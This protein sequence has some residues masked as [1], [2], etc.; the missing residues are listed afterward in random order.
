MKYLIYTNEI[1]ANLRAD[2]CFDDL[3]NKDGTTSYCDVIKHTADDLWAVVVDNRTEYLFTPQELL[4]CVNLT[5]D[6]FPIIPDT[7]PTGYKRIN[8]KSTNIIKTGAGILRKIV[9]GIA[10]TGGNKIVVYNNTTNTG[11]IIQQLSTSVIGEYDLNVDFTIGLTIV[12]SLGISS[13]FTVY[14]E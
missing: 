14:Y 7:D 8:T 4:D 6:W 10:G 5:Y 9:I 13:D 11:S 12:C 2:K 3:I 1:Q